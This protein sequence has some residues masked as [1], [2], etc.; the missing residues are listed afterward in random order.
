MILSPYLIDKG[1]LRMAHNLMLAKESPIYYYRKRIPSSVRKF[2]T[3][4]YLTIS[5]RIDSLII[6]RRIEKEITATLNS[7]VKCILNDEANADFYVKDLLR[8]TKMIVKKFTFPELDIQFQQ[9]TRK[10][11]VVGKN[12]LSKAIED[13]I[14]YR[15]IKKNLSYTSER[16]IT[17]LFNTIRKI[18]GIR[19]CEEINESI[20]DSFVS[21]AK[22]RYKDLT[23]S[24]ALATLKS[25]LKYIA[26]KE[27]IIYKESFNDILSIKL[28]LKSPRA[29]FNTQQ[30]NTIFS[31]SYTEHM[32]TPSYYFIPLLSL[33]TGM[34]I[35]EITALN[36]SDVHFEDEY[37]YFVIR[38]S[39][40]YSGIRTVPVPNSVKFFNDF[41]HYYNLA[42]N[43]N[44]ELLFNI[45]SSS[46]TRRFSN[47]LKSNNISITRDIYGMEYTHTFHSLRHSYNV[48]LESLLIPVYLKDFLLGHAPKST[49]ATYSKKTDRTQELYELAT[50]KLNFSDELRDLPPYHF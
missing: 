9:L 14:E 5:T 8:I 22:S 46:M 47:L 20:L 39:K 31:P 48:K 41:K 12:L 6:A 37:F 19:Y 15:R 26:Q 18:L 42:A 44:Q 21:N 29:E 24:N 27:I 4:E 17:S 10:N 16:R 45:S 35:S 23:I 43:A 49:L 11:S 3:S 2:F 50:S 1:V 33:V 36:I 32:D 25:F 40:T 28:D 7:S 38:K 30:L 34:R 13:Y